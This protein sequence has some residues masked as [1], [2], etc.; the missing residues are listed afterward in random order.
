MLQHDVACNPDAHAL[1][2]DGTGP[3]LRKPWLYVGAHAVWIHG[4]ILNPEAYKSQ[5]LL[6]LCGDAGVCVL[7]K[8]GE[9]R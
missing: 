3:A 2:Q 1:A 7:R 8:V 9:Y 5:G 4:L 6:H